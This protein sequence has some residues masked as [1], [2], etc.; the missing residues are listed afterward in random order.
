MYKTKLTLSQSRVGIE[1]WVSITG[2]WGSSKVRGSQSSH[3]REMWPQGRGADGAH[4]ALVAELRAWHW[5]G[6]GRCM[7]EQEPQK[8]P[9]PGSPACNVVGPDLDSGWCKWKAAKQEGGD[10]DVWWWRAPRPVEEGGA[11]AG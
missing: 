9:C 6:A 10:T 4:L 2:L 8:P 1:G 5:A 7:E 11:E 3:S